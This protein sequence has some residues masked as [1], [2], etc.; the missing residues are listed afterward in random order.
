MR[1]QRNRTRLVPPLNH[2]LPRPLLL[3]DRLRHLR[4]PLQHLRTSMTSPN[5]APRAI[6]LQLQTLQRNFLDDC[7]VLFGLEAAPVHADVEAELD[8]SAH[9]V[10]RAGEAVHKSA[11]GQVREAGF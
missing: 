1:H 5:L 10:Q 6:R 9:L 11:F 4:R 7:K 2:V 8:E 3:L